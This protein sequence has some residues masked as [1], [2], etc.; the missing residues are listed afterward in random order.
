MKS[1]LLRIIPNLIAL[2]IF[3][4]ASWSVMKK[5][6]NI[7]IVIIIVLLG[8]SIQEA[9][10]ANSYR[11]LYIFCSYEEARDALVSTSRPYSLS[12]GGLPHFFA[13]QYPNNT[14][15]LNWRGAGF[16]YD[17]GT[18]VENVDMY[19]YPKVGIAQE[20]CSDWNLLSENQN[21]GAVKACSIPIRGNPINTA[22]GNKY[23]IETDLNLVS[24]GL[25][26][27]FKRYYNSQSDFDGPF[28]F[29]WTTTFS[30]RL[31]QETGKII[32]R[33]ANGAHIHF[34]DDGNG[35]FISETDRERIIET[36]GVDFVLKEPDGKRLAFD[37]NGNLTQITDK[38]GNTQ[39]LNYNLGILSFVEDNFGRRIDLSYNTQGRLKT[40]TC[41]LP[42]SYH[43]LCRISG[44]TI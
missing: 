43:T 23:Q 6:R 35:K 9:K 41:D 21:S 18:W 34:I 31:I 26:M 5:M 14:T 42:N 27:A 20:K 10:A 15:Y 7:A 30:E 24:I 11:Y 40:I 3:V 37:S 2:V 29:G 25:P 16:T 38:N 1:Y 33:Q 44:H 28:G 13:S 19:V 32:L 39:T 36:A 22:T 8:I 17:E 12:D 4:P